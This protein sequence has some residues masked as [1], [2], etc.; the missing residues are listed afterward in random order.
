MPLS[1]LLITQVASPGAT[2]VAVLA[3]PEAAS[4]QAQT[5][6]AEEQPVECSRGSNQHPDDN[7]DVGPVL[8][9]HASVL[10]EIGVHPGD[11]IVVSA[12]P[13]DA[14]ISPHAAN[15]RGIETLDGDGHLRARHTHAAAITA[16]DL[17]HEILARL[18]GAGDPK[19]VAELS[20]GVAD[21]LPASPGLHHG[22]EGAGGAHDAHIPSVGSGAVRGGAAPARGLVLSGPPGG[23]KS[24]ALAAVLGSLAARGAR[25]WLVDCG[26][27]ARGVAA[28]APARESPLLR[29][30]LDAVAARAA[31]PP[32][33]GAVASPVGGALP[34]PLEPLPVLLLDD[35]DLLFAAG[36]GGAGAQ[37]AGA[38]QALVAG[39]ERSALPPRARPPRAPLPRERG[40][41]G[42]TRSAATAASRSPAR[43]APPCRADTG[44]A[45]APGRMASRR[46]VFS[47]PCAMKAQS[48]VGRAARSA[49][50]DPC[51]CGSVLLL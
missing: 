28:G 16:G 38:V 35:L 36:A 13:P 42:I 40:A 29:G 32:A 3:V 12:A 5:A 19:L 15:N 27:L 46:A 47:R 34:A 44:S 33:S 39:A 51:V 17:E 48:R 26:Q 45:A 37:L 8:H 1:T 23:G 31:R 50:T 9:L 43:P 18:G 20:R 49:C 7:N 2:P 24:W 6:G 14:I 11:P 30:F 22:G 25:A 41:S 4:W 21:I 10:A